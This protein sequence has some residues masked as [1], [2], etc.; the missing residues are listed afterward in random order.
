MK[1]ELNLFINSLEAISDNY[2]TLQFVKNI[3][4][5]FNTLDDGKSYSFKH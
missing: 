1:E 4:L 5:E 2:A 3:V